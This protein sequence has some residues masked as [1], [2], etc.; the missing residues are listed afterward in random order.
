MTSLHRRAFR[1]PCVSSESLSAGF[2]VG[3]SLFMANRVMANRARFS[4]RFGSRNRLIVLPYC[5]TLTTGSLGDDK[6]PLGFSAPPRR[7][8]FQSYHRSQRGR[9]QKKSASQGDENH[10]HQ[11]IHL[12]F[13]LRSSLSEDN[14]SAH[15]LSWFGRRELSNCGMAF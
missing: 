4:L 2:S 11:L 15:K 10:F 7:T 6:R 13:L 1:T 3:S 14:I 5:S 9:H 12:S 8:G